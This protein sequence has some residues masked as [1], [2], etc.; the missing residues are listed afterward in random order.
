MTN[1][2]DGHG[3]LP[4]CVLGTTIEGMRDLFS[5]ALKG[6]SADYVEIHFEESQAMAC[7]LL[8]HLPFAFSAIAFL[9]SCFPSVFA[10][11]GSHVSLRHCRHSSLFGLWVTP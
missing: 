9:C 11:Q 3:S 7:L 10:R 2:D 1:H 8:G 6:H 5:D 4:S